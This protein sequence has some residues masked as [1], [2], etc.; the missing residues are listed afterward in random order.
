MMKN[1]ECFTREYKK[2]YSSWMI[3]VYIY[4]LYIRGIYLSYQRALKQV[5]NK[6]VYKY[7]F[8]YRRELL[9]NQTICTDMPLFYIGKQSFI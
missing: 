9:N 6:D 5:D 4:A 8:D 7:I 1:L 3:G 2:I